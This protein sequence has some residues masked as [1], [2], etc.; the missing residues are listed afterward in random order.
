MKDLIAMKKTIGFIIILVFCACSFAITSGDV[1]GTYFDA[2]TSNTWATDA[3]SYP[4]L[5][6]WAYSSPD[7]PVILNKWY[8][9][10]G[11]TSAVDGTAFQGAGLS[12]PQLTT[13]ITGLDDTKTYDV[14]VVFHARNV[15]GDWYIY[16]GMGGEDLALY[17][18]TNADYILGTGTL[19]S[20]QTKLGTI[21]GVDTFSIDVK[22][23]TTSV[24]DGYERTWYDGVAVIEVGDATIKSEADYPQMEYDIYIDATLDNIAPTDAA[25]YPT[26]VDWLSSSTTLNKW[27]LKEGSFS[28]IN[29][30]A[31]EGFGQSIP[32]L[33]MSIDNIDDSKSYDVYAVCW[34]KKPIGG[35]YWFTYAGIEGNN[36]DICDYDTA[37]ICFVEGV[38][39]VQ[40]VQKHLGQ[41]SGRS[42]LS[43]EIDAPKTDHTSRAWFDGVALVEVKVDT[44]S[45]APGQY[46]YTENEVVEINAYDYTD[47][48]D[49]SLFQR[50]IGD[51]AEPYSAQTTVVMDKD[52]TVI[53]V[54]GYPE[55]TEC[56]DICH[57]FPLGDLNKDCVVDLDDLAILATDWFAHEI[58]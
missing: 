5:S 28:A 34:V 40:G 54:F 47:C 17:D 56:G 11:S 16:A 52:K 27:Y 42:S 3:E 44:I 20:C 38:S 41:I 21:S 36:L 57:P 2:T 39:I 9:K 49:Y 24:A 48:P 58:N 46:D 7:T 32:K 6:D 43:V 35:E 14:Y 51:V 55:P 22:G 23:A 19:I 13:T 33:T 45:P 12:L 1:F 30:T 26:Q 31:F 37:E 10:T 4:E 18:E 53:A 25:S 15:G 8:M 29:G 50:W